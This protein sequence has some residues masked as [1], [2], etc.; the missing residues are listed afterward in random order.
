[1]NRILLVFIV[2]LFCSEAFGQTPPNKD[3][4]HPPQSA[5]KGA[6]EAKNEPG[7]SFWIG[8]LIG[9]VSALSVVLG[10]YALARFNREGEAD[11][12]LRDTAMQIARENWQRELASE[13]ENGT[14]PNGFRATALEFHYMDIIGKLRDFERRRLSETRKTRKK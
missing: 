8:S 9:L 7:L 10:Q 1:M 4:D 11:K 6:S 3:N 2:A 12:H 14:K 5:A 13:R